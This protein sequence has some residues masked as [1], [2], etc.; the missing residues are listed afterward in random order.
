VTRKTEI[1]TSL[2]DTITTLRNHKHRIF[3][4]AMLGDATLDEYRNFNDT[5]ER[6]MA[7]TETYL[8]TIAGDD[9]E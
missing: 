5:L 9:N 1:S 6:W 8:K 3:A 2:T 4:L 7:S